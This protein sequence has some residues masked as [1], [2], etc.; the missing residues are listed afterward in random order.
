MGGRGGGV[1]LSVLL[2]TYNERRNIALVAALLVEALDPLG[3]GYE[4]IVVDDSSPDGTQDVVRQLQRLYGEQRLLLQPRPGK[5]GLGMFSAT[6]FD[7]PV[8]QTSTAY[9]HGL[10]HALGEL[11]IIMDADLSHHPKYIPAFLKK[12]QE[13]GADIVTG[14]RYK[15]GGGVYGWD[16][17]RKLTSRGANVLAHTLLWPPVSDLTGSFRLYKRPVLE[18]LMKVCGSKGYVF[19]M[20]MIVRA[21]RSS[22]QVEEVPISFVDRLYGSSK[23]GGTEIVQY[24]IGLIWLFFTT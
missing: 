17:R 1:R 23:L 13:T 20:E 12:Q 11:I 15:G 8:F 4:I 9:A 10:K 5:L 3:I 21:T 2:P 19:Q 7:Y 6:A 16:L 18:Q 22:Y 24:L 14:T